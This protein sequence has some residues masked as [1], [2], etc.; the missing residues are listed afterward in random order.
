VAELVILSKSAGIETVLN[1]EVVSHSSISFEVKRAGQV[2]TRDFQGPFRQGLIV[3]FQDSL[4]KMRHGL[5]R[6]APFRF[7]WPSKKRLDP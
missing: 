5:F 1:T 6:G 2:N 4:V 3:S 7:T